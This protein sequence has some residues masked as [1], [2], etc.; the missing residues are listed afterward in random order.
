MHAERL[1]QKLIPAT[2]KRERLLKMAR[3]LVWRFYKTLKAYKQNPL[4]QSAPA[5]RR[6]F[7]RIFAMHTGYEA[8]DK[9][10]ERLHR[11]KTELLKVL[12]Y[13]GIPPHTNA[14]ENALRTFVTK[15]KISGGRI[16]R[17]GRVA[18]DVMLGPIKTCQS[19]DFPSTTISETDLASAMVI[20]P[21]HL[22]RPPSSPGPEHHGLPVPSAFASH[23]G[24]A[25]KSAPRTA[26][27]YRSELTD[28]RRESL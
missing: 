28:E 7:D 2:A 8:F 15:R 27:H 24:T 18:R 10:L 17:D 3:D 21:S 26:A 20:I 13:P 12:D 4:P 19:L 11:R 6:R 22:S 1:L 23:I 5:F 9:L 14:S 16:N 25:I